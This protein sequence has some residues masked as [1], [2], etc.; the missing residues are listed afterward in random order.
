MQGGLA[1]HPGPDGTCTICG[2]WVV[3]AHKKVSCG[4]CNYGS[5]SRHMFG[6]KCHRG[7]C[8]GHARLTGGP[9]G[10]AGSLVP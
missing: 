6:K 8:Q 2:K 1:F 4:A 3:P 7:R 9:G 5:R 10:G